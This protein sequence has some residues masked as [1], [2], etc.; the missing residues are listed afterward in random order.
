MVTSYATIARLGEYLPP[1]AVKRILDRNGRVLAEFGEQHGQRVLSEDA[2]AKLIDMLRGAVRQ[3]TGQLVRQQ[4][5]IAA[6]VAG[7]TGTT[8]NNTDG[9]FILMH[10]ELVAGAWIG[11]NDQRITMRSTYWGQGGHNAIL[12]VG[13]FFRN[14][15]RKQQIDIAVKFPHPEPGIMM[16]DYSSGNA[17]SGSGDDADDEETDNE[18]ADMQANDTAQDQAVSQ[19]NL[20]RGHG[21][22][23][24]RKGERI[25]IGDAPG[26]QNLENDRSAPVSSNAAAEIAGALS[27]SAE[28][29][30]PNHP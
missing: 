23:V 25:L 7:K 14:A 11:F 22:I 13:D 5:G 30:T 4:F 20:P 27:G 15:L 3:G 8:Q 9:W 2:S 18:D 24:R 28:I 6:D 1:V 29:V 12:V 19:A 26:I 21:I 17:S 16:A 10:P